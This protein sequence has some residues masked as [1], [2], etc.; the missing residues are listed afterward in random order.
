MFVTFRV[1]I[2]AYTPQ[3]YLIKSKRRQWNFV[4]APTPEPSERHIV[5]ARM[6]EAGGRSDVARRWSEL[7]FVAMSGSS[8]SYDHVFA[9]TQTR[10][11]ELVQQQLGLF[12]VGGVEAL[13]EPAVDWR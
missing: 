1:P 4:A 11:F 5:G 10:S 2:Q 8:V 13:G 3:V 7:P 6:S 9:L 12:Q